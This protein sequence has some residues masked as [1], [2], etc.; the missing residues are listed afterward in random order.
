MKNHIKLSLMLLVVVATAKMSMKAPALGPQTVV[1]TGP[2]PMPVYLSEPETLR[3]K[4]PVA[5]RPVK[6]LYCAYGSIRIEDSDWKTLK[7]EP[8]KLKGELE[9]L[10]KTIN[11]A[12]EKV[13]AETSGVRIIPGA[14]PTVEWTKERGL[15][16]E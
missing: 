15:R 3:E 6:H 11:N 10:C 16:A 7:Q 14:R 13:V 5:G 4:M 12:P 8:K 2:E 9:K 1:S